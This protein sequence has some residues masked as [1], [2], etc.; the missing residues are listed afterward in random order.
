MGWS[1]WAAGL[2][3]VFTATLYCVLISEAIYQIVK[4]RPPFLPFERMLFKRLPA[5]PADSLLQGVSKLLVYVGI[6]IVQLPLVLSS[7]LNG[8]GTAGGPQPGGLWAEHALGLAGMVCA[9]FALFLVVCSA[10][11][12]SKI[13]FTYLGVRAK[14][15]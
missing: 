3:V 14:E 7:F 9:V 2:A 12:H 15:S 6:L 13:H 5:T 11:V 8:L 1:G 4:E 10:I